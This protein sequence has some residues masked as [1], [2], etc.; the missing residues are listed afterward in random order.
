M[1]EEYD[2]AKPYSPF[3]SKGQDLLRTNHIASQSLL[4]PEPSLTYAEIPI[5]NLLM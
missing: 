2:G 4:L 1:T 5:I 3:N